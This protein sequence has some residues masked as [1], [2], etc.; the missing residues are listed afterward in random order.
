MQTISLGDYLH[1]NVPG[2]K[3]NQTFYL[4]SAEC[5]HRVLKELEVK[6]MLY[7]YGYNITKCKIH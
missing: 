3:A 2:Q 5:A 1:W 4:S 7:G 6:P